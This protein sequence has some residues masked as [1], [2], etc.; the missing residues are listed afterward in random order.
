MHSLR[1]QKVNL[2]ACTKDSPWIAI[3]KRWPWRIMW[4]RLRPQ[5]MLTLDA[6]E[7]SPR[8][9]QNP[10]D[11]SMTALGLRIDAIR[12][13]YEISRR[14]KGYPASLVYRKRRHIRE[15]PPREHP[16]IL[17]DCVYD[18]QKYKDFPDSLSNVTIQIDIAFKESLNLRG[19]LESSYMT[20]WDARFTFLLSHPVPKNSSMIGERG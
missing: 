20:L 9:S 16:R 12:E 4:P 17:V 19:I 8:L 5:R 15:S 2:R 7:V 6:R 10:T 13:Y 11:Q 3:D 18:P 14:D 1:P